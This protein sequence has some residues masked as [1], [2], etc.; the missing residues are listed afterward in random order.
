MGGGVSKLGILQLKFW[1]VG[2]VGF[3]GIE[4]KSNVRLTSAITGHA[5]RTAHCTIYK[6]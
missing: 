5:L 6:E 1:L 4:F 3:E 2:F